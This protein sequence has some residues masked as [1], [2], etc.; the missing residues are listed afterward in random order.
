MLD[1]FFSLLSHPKDLSIKFIDLTFDFDSYIGKKNKIK[2]FIQ[3]LR[4][5]QIHEDNF[6]QNEFLRDDP[7]L[8]ISATV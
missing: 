6:D 3:K 8:L 7:F 5:L 4:V 1:R 2:F